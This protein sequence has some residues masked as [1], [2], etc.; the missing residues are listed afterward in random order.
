MYMCSVIQTIYLILMVSVQSFADV[1]FMIPPTG[2]CFEVFIIKLDLDL[3][4]LISFLFC[5]KLQSHASLTL[6][7]DCLAILSPGLS[8]HV[9]QQKDWPVYLL[10][11]DHCWPIFD[12]LSIQQNNW[13]MEQLSVYCC[14]I[15]YRM[16]EYILQH[17]YQNIYPK[18]IL[19]L[20][21]NIY[22]GDQIWSIIRSGLL[23]SVLMSRLD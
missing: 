19:D 15:S 1:G 22:T 10:V 21:S 11:K 23:D 13:L 12:L 6:V 4:I 9:Q 5:N 7:P 14:L 20:D 2:I 18:K 16:I 17:Y 8:P 3:E